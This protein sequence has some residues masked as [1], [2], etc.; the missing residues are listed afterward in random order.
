MNEDSN[1]FIIEHLGRGSV[2]YPILSVIEAENYLSVV[3]QTPVYTLNISVKKL[4][5]IRKKTS[6]GTLDKKLQEI[7][8][9][10]KAS[11]S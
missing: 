4:N 9:E 6:S 10:H 5:Y 3:C 2:L 8:S 1:D 7:V 11:E